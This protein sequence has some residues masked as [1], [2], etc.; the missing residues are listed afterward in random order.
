MTEG[1]I[2]TIIQLIRGGNFLK[3][4]AEAAGVSGSIVREW[5]DQGMKDEVDGKDTPAA[6]FSAR[7]RRAIAENEAV[8][9]MNVRQ[10]GEHDW[11]ASAWY[12]SVRA[13]ERFSQRSRLQVDA[14]VGVATVQ[15][16]LDP[17][18]ADAASRLLAALPDRPLESTG[19]DVGGEEPSLE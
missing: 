13:P 10:A 15:L 18:E 2:E 17:D 11:R 19:F 12:L 7:L 3:T 4:A 16:S 5:R 9:V 8:H 1:T 6:R 14:R